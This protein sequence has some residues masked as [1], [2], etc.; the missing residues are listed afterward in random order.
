[1]Q[2]ACQFLKA[3]LDPMSVDSLFFAAEAS[4]AISDCEVSSPIGSLLMYDN[5]KKHVICSSSNINGGLHGIK[6]YDGGFG[7]SASEVLA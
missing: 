5:N 4:Q 1:M 3:Q 7:C 6:T 2:D